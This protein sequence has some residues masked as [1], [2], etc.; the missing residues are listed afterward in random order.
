MI[1]TLSAIVLAATTVPSLA[2]ERAVGARL[3]YDVT[4]SGQ[5]GGMGAGRT[6]N[7]GFALTLDRVDAD[8]S[9]HAK[10]SISGAGLPA[11]SNFAF[12]A[13]VSPAGAIIPK[14]DPNIKM[15]AGMSEA[16]SLAFAENQAAM[17]FS[18]TLRPI[19]A[20]ASAC[21]QRAN[22]RVGDTWHA[23]MDVPFATDAI[24]TVTGQR[25]LLG[26]RVYAVS[27]Q[28]AA[29]TANTVAGQG[30][31]DST[32]HLVSVFHYTLTNTNGETETADFTLH[33]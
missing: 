18:T 3:L 24:Y 21:A 2:Q 33:Q 29:T 6:M 15:H 28:A 27:V 16:E 14:Y 19:N 1:T 8:G 4:V 11:S 25:D 13:T 10:A 31:Y 30:S 12:D 22:P 9:A 5:G 26:H 20:F 32:A 17:V 23:E 7:M